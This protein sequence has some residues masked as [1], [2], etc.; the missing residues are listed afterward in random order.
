MV[1]GAL[2]RCSSAQ[3]NLDDEAEADRRTRRKTGCLR[4]FAGETWTRGG[5]EPL[6]IADGRYVALLAVNY[7]SDKESACITDGNARI[8]SGRNLAALAHAKW[9]TIAVREKLSGHGRPMLYCPVMRGL[10]ARVT[11]RSGR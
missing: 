7:G 2:S 6:R 5:A 4:S 11:V 3:A 9:V 1:E 8:W 10:P